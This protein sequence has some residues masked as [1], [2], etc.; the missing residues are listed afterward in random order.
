[1]FI[2]W[3]ETLGEDLRSGLHTRA[4]PLTPPSHR[5]SFT[6]TKGNPA[7]VKLETMYQKNVIAS[8]E[9]LKKGKLWSIKHKISSEYIYIKNYPSERW[10]GSVVE[11]KASS[12]TAV[13]WETIS[14]SGLQ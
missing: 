8:I 2:I 12:W 7:W 5:V 3:L 13:V 6:C 1:M 14:K 10:V 9:Y 4:A 11:V